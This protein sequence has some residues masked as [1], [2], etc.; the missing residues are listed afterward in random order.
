M[1]HLV[2]GGSGFI[3]NLIARRLHARGQSVRVLDI[4]E[5]PSRPREIEFVRCDIRDRDGV[6]EAMRGVD[7]V[8]HNV[9]LVP[10]SKAGRDFWAVNV[11]G[12]RVA[13][14]QACK[15]GV[16]TFIHM[17]SSAVFGVP[18]KCPVTND[19]PLIPAEI[20]GRAKLAGEIAVREVCGS[21]STSLIVIRPPHH[22]WRRATWDFP[23]SFSVDS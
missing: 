5:D 7:V 19:S 15:A 21:S 8:H 22:A 10:L 4:W 11:D 16:K 23:D 13:A 18:E 3:G 17:S 2:T 14:E 12:A 20:Y 1:K 9:A 6:A